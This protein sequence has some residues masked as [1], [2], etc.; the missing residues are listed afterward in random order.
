MQYL[1]ESWSQA[2]EEWKKSTVYIN[3]C[4]KSGTVRRGVRKWVTKAQLVQSV[5]REVA[6]AIIENK[7]NN[8]RLRETEVRTHPD[9]MEGDEARLSVGAQL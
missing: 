9:A 6:E 7:M 4:E 8:E 2:A 1:F 3:V 5:G